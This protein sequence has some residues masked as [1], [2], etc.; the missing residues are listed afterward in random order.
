MG[1]N[2]TGIK[3]IFKSDVGKMRVNEAALDGKSLKDLEDKVNDTDISP[4]AK[5]D[6]EIAKAE[7][8]IKDIEQIGMD[9]YDALPDYLVGILKTVRVIPS[10]QKRI[11]NQIKSIEKNYIMLKKSVSESQGQFEKFDSSSMDFYDKKM[12]CGELISTYEAIKDSLLEEKGTVEE[13]VKES[14]K[15][16][17]NNSRAFREQLGKIRRDINTTETKI[18]DYAGKYHIYDFKQNSYDR[19]RVEAKQ[20]LDI[21]ND[22]KVNTEILIEEIKI[23][24]EGNR[25][26]PVGFMRML[27]TN[28]VEGEHVKG[29]ANKLREA[30]L[31]YA[32]IPQRKPEVPKT[33]MDEFKASQS[34][35]VHTAKAL[36]EKELI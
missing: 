18:T 14:Q 2:G 27:K 29:I 6:A 1:V 36:Y 25:Y 21:V 22:A 11:A 8:Y 24:T 31:A 13:K 3:E 33:T 10:A 34:D 7:E 23:H 9:K 19:F 28:W 4:E 30:R 32:S 26:D 16:R 35:I 20:K 12:A 17:D 15:N 5:F